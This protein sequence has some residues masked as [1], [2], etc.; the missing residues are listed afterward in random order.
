VEA[1]RKKAASKT[2]VQAAASSPPPLTGSAREFNPDLTI[3]FASGAEEALPEEVGKL[4]RV[5]AALR[6]SP[7]IVVSLHGYSDSRGKASRNFILSVGRAD[8]V[9]RY[10]AGKGCPADRVLVIGHGAAKFLGDNGS[11]RG[12]R[13]NR[14]VE[15]EIHNAR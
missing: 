15:I 1:T 10:L 4:D 7:E 2:A 8:S 6:Q 11:E 9:K 5:A 3:F 13:L 12:R 14:R